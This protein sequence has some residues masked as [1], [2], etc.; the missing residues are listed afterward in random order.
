MEN[1]YKKDASKKRDNS[2]SRKKTQE[3]KPN[4]LEALR[5]EFA[6]NQGVKEIQDISTSQT[7]NKQADTHISQLEEKSVSPNVPANKTQAI[8]ETVDTTIVREQLCIHDISIAEF[9]QKCDTG[10]N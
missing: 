2:K 4:D 1:T 5:D 7:K 6:K 10:Y 3:F 9:C 8:K